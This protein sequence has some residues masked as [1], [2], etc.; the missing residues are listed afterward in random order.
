[1]IWA[2]VIVLTTAVLV[3]D[4][5]TP[6]GFAGGVPYVAVMLLS[7]WLPRHRDI[8]LFGFVCSALVAVGLFYSPPGGP[9][10][11]VLA[12]R[13]L[14]VFAIWATGFFLIQRKK[15][16][17]AIQTAN[18]ELESRVRQRIGYWADLT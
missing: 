16:E 12:N 4:L 9:L 6:L 8:I 15:T 13:G 3:I 11:Q 5:V 14:A 17:S 18:D 1:L 10:F 2:A 7:A